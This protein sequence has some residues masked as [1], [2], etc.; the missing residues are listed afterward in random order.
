M[1]SDVTAEDLLA[2]CEAVYFIPESA[3]LNRQLFH[4]QENSY[5]RISIKESK[6]LFRH[7]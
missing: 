1:R 4:F 5:D 3:L 2:V 7:K 6:L